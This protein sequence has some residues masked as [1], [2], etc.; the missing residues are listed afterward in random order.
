MPDELKTALEE[1]AWFARS[2]KGDEK[3]EAQ[4]FLDHFFRAGTWRRQRSWRDVGVPH[5]EE[6]RLLAIGTHQR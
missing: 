5:R 3:G 6:T 4:I 1:F 2:L